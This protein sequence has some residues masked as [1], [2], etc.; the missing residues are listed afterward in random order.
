MMQAN[1]DVD[2][3]H[4]GRMVSSLPYW[5]HLLLKPSITRVDSGNKESSIFRS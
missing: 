3:E 1:Q 2:H 4:T 5:T